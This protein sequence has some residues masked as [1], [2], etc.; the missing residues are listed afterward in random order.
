ML[1]KLKLFVDFKKEEDWLNEWLQKGYE[2][3]NV[4]PFG[5][6]DP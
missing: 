1:K 3:T 6:G 4:N 5:D 2:L